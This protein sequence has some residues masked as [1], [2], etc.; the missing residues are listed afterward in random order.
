[1]AFGFFKKKKKDSLHYD[2]ANIR[3]TD[4]RKGFVLDYDLK[5][6]LV[7]EEYEYDW[8]NNYFSYEYKLLSS[9]D[10]LFLS[11]ENDDELLC[12]LSKKINFA[13]FDESIEKRIQKKGKPPKKITFKD[14]I[15]YRGD[16]RPGF[17]RNVAI[18]AHEDSEEFLSWEYVDNSGKYTLTIEQWGEGEFEASLGIIIDETAFSNIL[19]GGD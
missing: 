18:T 1:M 3:L 8:G 16:E 17:F 2:P 4:L 15:Y 12:N 13:L 10:T 7:K 19:P 9:D 5:T 14:K 11:V 6:W